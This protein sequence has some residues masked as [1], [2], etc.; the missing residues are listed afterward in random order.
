MK[1]KFHSPVLLKCLGAADEW[2]ID[3]MN[4]EIITFAF[5]L[6]CIF[7]R[8]RFQGSIIRELKYVRCF[9]TAL[10]ILSNILLRFSG[11]FSYL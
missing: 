4:S 9:I 8:F 1:C 6:Y 3:Y 5:P 10:L 2:E 7:H 11:E